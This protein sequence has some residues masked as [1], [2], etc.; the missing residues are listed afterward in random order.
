ME[1]ALF[2]GVDSSIDNWVLDSRVSFYSTSHRD[3][4]QNNVVCDFGKKC[5]AIGE[6]L[7]V[8]GRIM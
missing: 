5:M 8:V 4:I 2:L 7:D 6:L 1:D 3:I